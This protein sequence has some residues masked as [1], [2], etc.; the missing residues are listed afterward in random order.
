MAWYR[1]LSLRH[2]AWRHTADDRVG[3]LACGRAANKKVLGRR[4][5][6]SPILTTKRAARSS[7]LDERS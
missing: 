3:Y 1:A 2:A 4:R 5:P 7:A 6:A